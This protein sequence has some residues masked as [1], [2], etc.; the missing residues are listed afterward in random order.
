MAR[1]V[2]DFAAAH[3]LADSGYTNLVTRLQGEVAQT[4][5]LAKLQ[6][7]GQERQRAAQGRRTALKRLV[8]SQ[9]LRRLCRIAAQAAQEHP[10]LA[11]MFILPKSN[12]PIRTF[13]LK[14]EA[15]LADAVTEKDLLLSLNL[16]DTFIADLT[17]ALQ[18]LSAATETAHGAR[19]DHIGASGALT[20]M[21]NK[22]TADVSLIDTFIKANF[23]NDPE[24][25][26]AWKS[27]RKV[28][29]RYP[30]ATAP[31]APPV[32]PAPTSEGNS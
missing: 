11:G 5:T 14:A 24:T 2:T 9:Q 18:E 1:R 20:Q 21:V 3:P 17:Q 15:M 4:D 19:A 30:V 32:P 6:V 7:T 23:A 26:S 31:V 27:V 13:L 12:A 29:T 8:W 28:P 16:G 10:E 25:L 22:C